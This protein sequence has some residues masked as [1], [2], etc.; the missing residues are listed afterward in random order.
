MSFLERTRNRVSGKAAGT[1]A[2]PASPQPVRKNDVLGKP[3]EFVASPASPQPETA[4][5]YAGYATQ[6]GALPKTQKSRPALPEQVRAR[7][8]RVVGQLVDDAMCFYADD[9]EDLTVM[10][11]EALRDVV[12]AYIGAELYVKRMLGIQTTGESN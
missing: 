11:P 2:S 1:V 8:T 5:G 3:K 10:D 9:F 12:T 6:Y 7:L 4:P